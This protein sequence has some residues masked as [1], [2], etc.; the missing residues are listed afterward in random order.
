MPTLNVEGVE[1]MAISAD[2]RQSTVPFTFPDIN[3]LSRM[4]IRAKHMTILSFA[5]VKDTL[6]VKSSLT[7]EFISRTWKSQIHD[8]E[9]KD[10]DS[11][12]PTHIISEA[13]QHSSCI[14]LSFLYPSDMEDPEISDRRI[15]WINANDLNL[16][17]K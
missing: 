12:F 8:Y 15:F 16:V 4:Q 13:K 7:K 5:N 10:V 1:E 3:G 11:I 17:F 2:S 6:L 14:S 9:T